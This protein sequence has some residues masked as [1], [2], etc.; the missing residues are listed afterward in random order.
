MGVPGSGK[1]RL[2]AE[3]VAR[4]YRRLNRDEEGGTMRELHQRLDGVLATGCR[5]VVLDN[6]YLTRAD[7]SYVVELAERHGTRV[8]CVWLDAPLAQTQVNLVRRLLERFD[9]LP[10]PSQLKDAA[11]VEQ[12]LLSPTQQMRAFRELEPP[13]DDEGF[14]TVERLPFERATTAG[15]PGVFVAADAAGGLA[16]ARESSIAPHLVF[17]WRPGGAPEELDQAVEI[18]RAKVTGPVEA[19]VCPHPGG[20]PICWC[21]P[22]LP[23][24]LLE[25]AHRHGVEPARSAVVGTS[26]AHRTLASALGARFVE[27]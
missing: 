10:T 9:G 19:A 23:G 12:G 20:P 26:A 7:R 13:G 17:D 18:V 16:A 5:E 2:A 8:R 4:G 3:Y 21:R 11:R 15:A 1:S 25:F 27:P 6:T 14:A 22:P 24:L